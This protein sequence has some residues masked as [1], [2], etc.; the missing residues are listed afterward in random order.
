[1]SAPRRFL[2]PWSVIYLPG[3]FKVVD[4]NGTS[5]AY[6]YGA[7]DLADKAGNDILTRDETRRIAANI[8]RLPE[9]LKRP[10]NEEPRT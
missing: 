2:P 5:V 3:G 9:L 7:D 1:M 4:S 8:C 6:C 10:A